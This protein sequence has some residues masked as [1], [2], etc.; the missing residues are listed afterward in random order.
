MRVNPRR[1]SFLKKVQAL[2]NALKK[3][4]SIILTAGFRTRVSQNI[5]ETGQIFDYSNLF[6]T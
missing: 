4:L 6:I 1:R 3:Y 2:K 5:V